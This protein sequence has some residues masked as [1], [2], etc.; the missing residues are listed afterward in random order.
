MHQH[1]NAIPAIP[2]IPAVPAISYWP[3]RNMD[4]F[5]Y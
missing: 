4:I 1:I 5:K 3:D 2:A